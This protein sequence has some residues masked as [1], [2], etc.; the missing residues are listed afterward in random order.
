MGHVMSPTKEITT[1]LTYNDGYQTVT[2]VKP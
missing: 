1:I 2:E